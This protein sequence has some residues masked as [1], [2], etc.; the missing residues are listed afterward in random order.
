MWDPK[1]EQ[2]ECNT[3]TLNNDGSSNTNETESNQTDTW[4]FP[5]IQMGTF[6]INQDYIVTQKLWTQ[7]S[8]GNK[9]HIGSGYFN[10]TQHY[11]DAILRSSKAEFKILAASEKVKY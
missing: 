11:I 8:T 6:G 1:N 10:L 3:V 2:T 4:I 9:I 7:A 5:L